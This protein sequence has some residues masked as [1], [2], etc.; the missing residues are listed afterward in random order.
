MLRFLSN[1]HDPKDPHAKMYIAHRFDQTQEEAWHYHCEWL[2]GKVIGK[3]QATSAYTVEELEK[4]GMV[5]V[6]IE[7]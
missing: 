3:P 5:G 1:T 7:E 4:M 2:K 6:Y